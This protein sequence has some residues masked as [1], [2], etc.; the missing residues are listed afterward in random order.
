MGRGRVG[1]GDGADGV[2]VGYFEEETGTDVVL[3]LE[4]AWIE[5]PCWSA[6]R[7]HT[8]RRLPDN[9]HWPPHPRPTYA[10]T[11]SPT[12]TTVDVNVR[13]VDERDGRHHGERSRRRMPPV[14][15]PV[16]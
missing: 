14:V 9:C 11:L 7:T 4:N 5:Q 10:R 12:A 2:G 13:V 16:P 8:F 6:L 3:M 1:V 15:L